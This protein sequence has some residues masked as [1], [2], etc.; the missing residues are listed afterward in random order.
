MLAQR[1]E[2][3][4][5]MAVVVNLHHAIS[6]ELR[7]A[8]DA[9][10]SDGGFTQEEIRNSV[11]RLLKK[12]RLTEFRR[13]VYLIATLKAAGVSDLELNKLIFLAHPSGHKT[14]AVLHKAAAR[15]SLP[16]HIGI[17][18]T[19]LEFRTSDRE[20][21]F[22]HLAGVR[23]LICSIRA[24]AELIEL[25]NLKKRCDSIVEAG[26]NRAALERI[27]NDWANAFDAYRHR[28]TGG[29]HAHMKMRFMIDYLK[30]HS[31]AGK[32]E[33]DSITS[34]VVL[35]F[36]RNNGLD[37]ALDWKRYGTVHDDFVDLL[38]A[39]DEQAGANVGRVDLD[40]PDFERRHAPSAG[41]PGV[42]D[43]D[44]WLAFRNE[45]GD[46]KY[47]V[48]VAVTSIELVSDL[49]VTAHRL[50][51]SAMRATRFS[52]VENRIKKD[53]TIERI[54]QEVANAPDAASVCALVD[55]T[56]ERLTK[57][58]WASVQI[59]AEAGQSAAI[60]ILR[61]VM[62][63]A[64]FLA[65]FASGEDQ[66][67]DDIEARHE[68]A[69]LRLRQSTDPAAVRVRMLARQAAA[70]TQRRGFLPEDLPAS[71]AEHRLMAPNFRPAL[72]HLAQTRENLRLLTET[73]QG[74]DDAAIFAEILC[75]IHV[76]PGDKET[77]P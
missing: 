68:A 63:T 72:R 74:Q 33:L 19:A 18:D 77:S 71:I 39:W 61:A 17:S 75:G 16:S 29:Y 30:A 9:M 3:E 50:L 6:D 52:L 46:V 7:D 22:T 48:N 57:A 76:S 1:T 45:D 34:K 44:A 70:A 32:A 60:W 64:E 11:T 8:W 59:L 5:R 25:Y 49:P 35:D 67:A 58:G 41:L 69:L 73:G 40:D 38:L 23:R 4:G 66:D 36:W 28:R 24:V 47:L 10:S 62:A 31:P 65:L 21:F 12:S 55:R 56:H 14:L 53:W 43:L 15:R 26:Q 20:T 13:I 27:V 51:R 54:R 37:P 2:K 42:G